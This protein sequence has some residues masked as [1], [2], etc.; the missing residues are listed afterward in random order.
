VKDYTLFSV[1]DFV[2]DDCF[3]TW[4]LNPT[5]DNNAFWTAW[6]ID[7]PQKSD[8]VEAARAI[9]IQLKFTTY[10]LQADEV[11]AL[12]D[13]IKG[14]EAV[15]STD[16]SLYRFKM[17]AAVAAMLVVGVFSFYW[18]AAT[19]TREYHTAF[20]ETKTIVLPDSSRVILNSNSSLTLA[21]SDWSNAPAREV[22][23]QGEAFFSVTHKKNNQPFNV[24]VKE[25]VNI[26]VLGTT[27]NVYHRTA[28]TKVVLNT[29]KIRLSL[30]SKSSGKILMK[31]GELVEVHKA[32]Y[33]RKK[34]DP[35]VYNAWTR[36]NLVLNHTS[37]RDIIA[38]LKDNYGV[39][40]QVNEELLDQTVS[41]S[42]PLTD[43][44]GLILQVAK[45]FRLKVV[46]EE[47]K[48]SLEE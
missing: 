40:V 6:L 29:G 11:S 47:N 15:T 34:V 35:S 45:A 48:I 37:L 17:L 44:N 14:V 21:S 9:I 10:S 8:D 41:G 36:N 30:P 28:N 25:G 39:D 18:F 20:G 26:E 33:V 13:R 42:M 31:P 1:N 19:K 46:E 4:V 38:M 3:Q 43:A 22:W 27:F 24:K 7:N 16:F 32:K 5:D 12:W 2:M 23:L